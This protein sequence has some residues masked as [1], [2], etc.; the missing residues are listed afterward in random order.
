MKT[1]KEESFGIVPLSKDSE[2]WKVFVILHKEGNHWG[3]PKGRKAAGENPKETAARELEEETGLIV[4]RYLQ[5]EPMIESYQFRSR[6]QLVLK[7]VFYFPAVV[8]GEVKLQPEEIR[9]GKWILLK[10]AHHHLTF[11]EARSICQQVMKLV[12]RE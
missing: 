3:F 11:Q 7:S 1:I 8:T 6:Y 2:G 5:E 9:D 4:E 12:E 10:E